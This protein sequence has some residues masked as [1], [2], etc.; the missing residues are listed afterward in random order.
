MIVCFIERGKRLGGVAGA[1][2]LSEMDYACRKRYR[3]EPVWWL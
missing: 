3:V 1:R 2:V